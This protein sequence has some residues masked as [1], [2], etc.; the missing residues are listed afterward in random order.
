[1]KHQEGSKGVHGVQAVHE[2]QIV[3]TMNELD[4]A[5]VDKAATAALFTSRTMNEWLSEAASKPVP[6]RLF[7][8]FWAEGELTI[9]FADT[10]AGKSALAV[11]I[12][13]SVC[14]GQPITGFEL[15]APQQSVVYFDFELTEMQLQRRYAEEHREG[16]GIWYENHFR[17]HESFLRVEI[18]GAAAVFDATREWETLLIREIERQVEIAG[19]T[20][21]VLDNITYLTREADKGKFALPLMQ[22]LN[23]LKKENLLSIL[24]L[25]HTPKRDESRPI[26]LNDLAGSKILANFADSVFAIGKS[27]K[28]KNLRYLKQL[29]A[30][31]TDIVHDFYNVAVCG[32]E[33]EHNY[34]GFRYIETEEESEHLAIMST[35]DRSQLV[36]R[37]KILTSQGKSQR[38]I[39][40]ELGIALGTVN[41]YLKS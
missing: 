20:V 1:V 6:K 9:L 36:D 38:E 4:A 2:S 30:R 23:D 8:N 22:R 29:K 25:A 41:K 27:Q 33:K 3:N 28:D 12:A 16:S 14:S 39:A 40:S 26:S 32:F 15:E 37:V 17:F 35:S 10:G 7:D 5:K 34:L 18:N 31:S 21:I 24:V 13:N 19:S 11:Q